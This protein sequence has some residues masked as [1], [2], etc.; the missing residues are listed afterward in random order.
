MV[1]PQPKMP[2][3]IVV[4]AFDWNDDGELVTAFGPQDYASEERAVRQAQTLVPNHAGV[5]AWSREANP[6]IG[7]YGE[8]VTLFQAGDMPDME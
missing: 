3:L 6:D 1:H 7:E 8:P 2:K 4:M 5:I